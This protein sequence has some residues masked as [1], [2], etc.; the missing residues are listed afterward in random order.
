[1]G[2]RL[3]F[4]S[5]QHRSSTTCGSSPSLGFLGLASSPSSPS[6]TLPSPTR[7][8]HSA[9]SSHTLSRPTRL[10]FSTTTLLSSLRAWED[11]CLPFSTPTSRSSGS[12]SRS[13][14]PRSLS[15]PSCSA[16]AEPLSQTSSSS[17][18]LSGSAT[19]SLPLSGKPLPQSASTQT[20][21]STRQTLPESSDPSTKSS[22]LLLPLPNNPHNHP[23]IH[24]HFPSYP[25]ISL[26]TLR[27]PW[28]LK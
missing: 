9:Q 23:R 24:P 4:W 14:S 18:T 21:T 10:R 1:M 13:R 20:P 6:A 22:R 15:R 2:N 5:C 16:S 11:T 8:A 17:L 3:G 27:K 12:L 25:L 7:S 26:P 19:P 28:S